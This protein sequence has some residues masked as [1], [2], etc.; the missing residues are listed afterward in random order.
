MTTP[1]LCKES[2]RT[3]TGGHSGFFPYAREP[4][5]DRGHLIRILEEQATEL[6]RKQSTFLGR[7]LQMEEVGMIC[8]LNA[9]ANKVLAKANHNDEESLS[10]SM[11][12]QQQRIFYEGEKCLQK[13]LFGVHTKTRRKE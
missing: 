12:F 13:F 8:Q 7:C 1:Y 3:Q 11:S 2:H 10:S 4:D 5:S 9:L 6:Y